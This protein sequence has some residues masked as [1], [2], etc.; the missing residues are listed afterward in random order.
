MHRNGN[1]QL[2]TSSA[3]PFMTEK[4]IHFAFRV[5]D[6]ARLLEHWLVHGRPERRARRP[7]AAPAG[8][9]P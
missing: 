8:P 6:L 3:R 5:E 1:G 2:G 9:A 4:V 7:D